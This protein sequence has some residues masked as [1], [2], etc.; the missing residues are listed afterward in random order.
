MMYGSA[1]VRDC[2]DMI[3][4]Y[5]RGWMYLEYQV[6]TDYEKVLKACNASIDAQVTAQIEAA[7]AERAFKARKRRVVPA[8]QVQ[9]PEW[10]REP[11]RGERQSD[12]PAFPLANLP[13]NEK[14]GL[15][16]NYGVTYR[17]KDHGTRVDVATTWRYIDR[18]YDLRAKYAA[19]AKFSR[20][21]KQQEIQDGLE[22]HYGFESY[23]THADMAAALEADEDATYEATRQDEEW[24]LDAELNW[25]EKERQEDEAWEEMC[26]ERLA[27][28]TAILASELGVCEVDESYFEEVR[29]MY[30]E[31]VYGSYF[32]TDDAPYM[33]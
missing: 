25:L 21:C 5:D 13:L 11:L 15:R 29:D 32:D 24:Q 4:D 28:S 1:L 19:S 10:E 26:R 3:D 31:E 12:R 2:S 9:L 23:C 27:Y 8:A 22:D 30:S 16:E 14:D 20:S 7:Y 33:D 17:V 18:K 6:E